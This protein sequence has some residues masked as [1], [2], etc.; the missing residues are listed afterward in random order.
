MAWHQLWAP[1]RL[2]ALQPSPLHSRRT[3]HTLGDP[4]FTDGVA[5]AEDALPT[6]PGQF[7][8]HGVLRTLLEQGSLWAACLDVPRLGD[9]PGDHTPRIPP[10]S[11]A[12][13][14]PLLD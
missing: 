12:E 5:S 3:T 14:S 10:P 2:T 13:V 9:I 6:G 7:Q 11:P 4:V 8:P 1:L